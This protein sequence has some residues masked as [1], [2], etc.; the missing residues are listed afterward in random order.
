[1][2]LIRH[3]AYRLHPLRVSE[4]L[5][6]FLK[7]ESIGGKLVIVAAFLS[8]VV[9]NSPLQTIFYGFWHQSLSI[10]L[11]QW[12]LSLPLIEWLNEGL[13]ALFFLVVGLEIKREFI[14][15][16][17]REHRT[18]ILPIGAAVG[19]VVLPAILYL[20][21]A[22]QPNA[23]HGWGVAISTDTAIAVAMLSLLGNRVPIQLKIFLLTLAVADDILAILAIG[24]F[25]TDDI[26]HL[27]IGISVI[28]IALVYLLR[29]YLS[30]RFLLVI[31]LGIILWLTT[32][33]SGVH[34]SIV[35][36][37]MGLLAPISPRGR[38]VST[39]EKVERFF[40][41]LTT[42]IVVPLFAFANAG[43]VFSPEPFAT[44]SNVILG[45]IFGLLVGKVAGITFMSWLLVRLGVADLPDEVS[46]RHIVG[47]G[48]IAGIG[49]TM[50]LFIA[51]SAFHNHPD[52]LDAS[53]IGIFIA[54]TISALIGLLILS[55]GKNK[56]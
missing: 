35:G 7:D 52:E 22:T 16:E 19:G 34:G 50:S 44:G 41:P 21:F 25:Y 29:T 49:F 56:S 3:F 33:L 55:R 38:L 5:G 11:G 14:R 15:G 39:P 4:S 32:H 31:G 53:K 1:M 26:N 13:M 40:L 24:L 42:L 30:K 27:F 48:F 51:D 9:V 45:V 17:L 28:V 46:W 20:D 47:V 8:L 12:N 54:S 6:L 43:F 2:E 37:I 18:A 10:G 36:V 23:I